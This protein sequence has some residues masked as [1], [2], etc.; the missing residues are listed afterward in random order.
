MMEIR[1]RALSGVFWST[2]SSVGTSLLQLIQLAVLGRL[3]GAE[4]FGLVAMA[5]VV[6]GIAGAYADVG[7][8]NAILTHREITTAQLSSLYWLNWG[9]SLAVA[10]LM[11]GAA[12]LVALAFSEP[13]LVPLVWWTAISL[14]IVP[15]GLQ[16]QLLMQRELRIK[17]IAITE[18]FS[19]SV[20]FSAAVYFAHNGWGA[21]SI[22]FGALATAIVKSFSL[23]MLGRR[24]WPISLHFSSLD[25]RPYVAFGAYQVGERTLN[26]AHKN[27]DKVLIGS[28][29]GA[30]QL[31]LYSVAYQLMQKPIQFVQPIVARV[32]LPLFASM[33]EN[34]ERLRAAYLLIMQALAMLMFPIFMFLI[35]AAEPLVLLLLGPGWM[36]AVPVL[37]LLSVLGLLY[38]IGFIVGS[39][40]LARKRADI[41]FWLNVWA[42]VVYAIAIACG[43]PWG[44]E[45][46]AM[47][48][49]LAQLIGLF[50]LGFWVR[51]RV[52][53]M[54]AGEYVL[55]FFPALIYA[56]LAAGFAHA[57]WSYTIAQ[58]VEISAMGQFVLLGL[59]LMT[60]YFIFVGL[61]MRRPLAR[62][63]GLYRSRSL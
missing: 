55:A 60:A 37:E 15:L 43:S 30:Q 26:F 14:A 35:A 42:L 12:P 46:V 52:V 36:A 20:G 38:S 51:W 50:S 62:F 9:A 34:P 24:Q 1:S 21:F 31:G 17:P 40:L 57:V 45:G 25:I 33:N 39:L 49:V 3:L 63:I 27:L 16:Y 11:A 28:L 53:G 2:F 29:L 47:S 5:S 56:A 18:V 59:A 7:M 41:A 44:I 54:R 48:L 22:V 6:A 58:R 13:R 61:F 8:S 23:F 32:A 4:E 10:V 19:A